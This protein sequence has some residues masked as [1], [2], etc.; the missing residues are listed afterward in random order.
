M[1]ESADR[2]ATVD[3]VSQEESCMRSVFHCVPCVFVSLYIVC[4]KVLSLRTE[5]S[6]RV[7][8]DSLVSLPG[9]TDLTC[10][11]LRRTGATAPTAAYQIKAYQ[12]VTS[13][14]P[15]TGALGPSPELDMLCACSF[16]A[17]TSTRPR[18]NYSGKFIPEV[19]VA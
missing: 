16:H 5:L 1:N 14:K 9:V 3:L 13:C 12:L 4:I 7:V 17:V 6:N 8:I 15:T 2:G 18:R 10:D 11:H 19:W